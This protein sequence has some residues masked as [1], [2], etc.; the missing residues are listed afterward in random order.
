LPPNVAS[1]ATFEEGQ[2]DLTIAVVWNDH[3]PRSLDGNG[4]GVSDYRFESDQIVILAAFLETLSTGTYRFVLSANGHL[5]EFDVI[6]KKDDVPRILDQAPFVHT[7]GDDT[8]WTS[9]LDLRGFSTFDVYIG[10]TKL[11][12]SQYLYEEQTL[13]IPSVTLDLMTPSATQRIRIVTTGGEAEQTFVLNDAV[14]IADKNDFIKLPGETIVNEN[15]G[16]LITNQIGIVTVAYEWLGDKGLFTDHGDG[17]FSYDPQGVFAGDQSIRM[18][19]TDAYG[20]TAERTFVL[21][22]KT[23]NPFVYDA[24]GL[25]LV[26]K[27]DAFD[28][29]VMTIDTYGPEVSS[30]LYPVRSIWLNGEAIEVSNWIYPDQQNNRFLA[31]KA[32]YLMTLEV[33]VHAFTVKTDAG[34]ATFTIEVRDT[35]AISIFESFGTYRKTVTERTIG[36][37]ITPYQH[38]ISESDFTLSNATLTLEDFTYDDNAFLFEKAFLESLPQ[39]VYTL[40]IQGIAMFTLTIQDPTA[41]IVAS[42]QK[43][44]LILK[45]TLADDLAVAVSFFGLSDVS[46]VKLQ[47]TV[48][49]PVI[50]EDG[51]VFAKEWLLSLAYGTHVV[52][53]ENTDGSDTITF[54]VSHAPA[55][56]SNQN[57]TKFTYETIS[58]EALRVQAV[59]PHTIASLTMLSASWIDFVETWSETHQTIEATPQAIL[60]DGVFGTITLNLSNKTFAM[61]RTPGWFGIVRFTYLATDSAGASATVTMEVVYKQ[62]PPQIADKDLKTYVYGSGTDG[63]HDIVYTVTNATGNSDFALI[64]VLYQGSPLSMDDMSFGAKVGTNRYF[65]IKASFL[66]TLSVGEHTLTLISAGGRSSFTIT[67]L[68]GLSATE[69]E[70]VFDQGDPQSVWFELSGNPLVVTG[71]E[72]AGSPVA[73]EHYAFVDTILTFSS[74]YLQTL[75]YGTHTFSVSNGVGAA[76]VRILIE[77]SRNAVCDCEHLG[78]TKGSNADV[79]VSFT[80]Y[81]KAFEG[82]LYEGAPVDSN[83][84]TFANATLTL[85]GSYLESLTE[86][87]TQLVFT[88]QSEQNIEIVITIEIVVVLPTIE[89]TSP[90]F[91]VDQQADLTF[92]FDL[93]GKT[94]D[95]INRLGVALTPNTDYVVDL[96]THVLTIKASYLLSIALTGETGASFV[97]ATVENANCGFLTTFDHPANRIVNGGFESGNL[98]GWTP[99]SIWKNE[100]GMM[101]WVDARVVSNTYFGSNIYRREGAYN[102]GI[103][104]N[105][106]VWDQSSERMGHLVS[107]TFTL[108]GSGWISFCLGGGRNNAFAYVSVRRAGDDVEVARFGNPNFNDTAKASAESGQTITNAEAFLFQYYFDLS[109]VAPLGT[110][111]YVTLSEIASYDWAILSADAFFA[112]HAEVPAIENGTLAVNIV[113]SI[114]GIAS[115]S[116]TIVNGYFDQGLDGWSQTASGWTIVSGQARSNAGGDAAIGALRSSAFVIGAN[117][118]IRM[119]WGGGLRWDKQIFLSVYEV[120][121]NFEVLRFVTRLNLS[122]KENENMD[123]LMLDLSSLDPSKTYYLH[124]SDNR[125]G[126]WGISYLDSIR[127][128]SETEY[129]TV[130]SG[131]R[132]QMIAGLPDIGKS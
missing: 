102:V 95:A 62:M 9:E 12:P 89:Q 48:L 63:T 49:S 29:V 65:T 51:V 108:S 87:K 7:V 73:A 112:Y 113:P 2:S 76:T 82:L 126:S 4:I 32:S 1:S 72:R 25:K 90:D 110:E 24:I 114:Q 74:T 121:T 117:K 42:S 132:A 28:D 61:S 83:H 57:V 84:Y 59:L 18:S 120:G 93:K 99:Y 75:D 46:T 6:V 17:R 81:D 131:D 105:D 101:S 70:R 111:L 39:G 98:S 55:V 53:I 97:L 16:L 128:V 78:Y 26:D 91:R 106:A 79:N 58:S 14:V 123:N 94:F 20:S 129:N 37:T 60:I 38:V 96:E 86:G 41:P 127:F 5:V 122:T 50:S 23:V 118:H 67:V 103:V 119:E 31:I 124:A 52:T 44:V 80:M 100:S 21:T 116:N 125:S 11:E 107:S 33:G 68:Q 47:D 8:V 104:W 69:E 45:E 36:F 54:Q 3:T 92:G 34:E 88:F 77:D 35:R 43:T 115:A 19:V 85:N 13:T 66:S 130:P 71:V 64:Q 22:Y 15:F 10:S 27:N 40:S 109:T 56:D 30:L